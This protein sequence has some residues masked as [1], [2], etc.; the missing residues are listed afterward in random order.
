VKP[1]DLP[2][3]ASADRRGSD[4]YRSSSHYGLAAITGTMT[5]LI[6]EYGRSVTA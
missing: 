1:L 3:R 2:G 6:H 5:S 4:Q